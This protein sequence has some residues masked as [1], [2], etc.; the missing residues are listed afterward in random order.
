MRNLFINKSSMFVLN[1]LGQTEVVDSQGFKTGETINTYSEPVFFMAH[2]SGARGS[3]QAEMFGT[4]INYDKTIL[5]SKKSYGVL[6]ITENSVFFIGKEPTYDNGI[7][8]YNYKVS[9]IAET[10]NEVAIAVSKVRAD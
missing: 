1:Y 4:E 10:I 2:I 8:L 3:S 7:P 5:L 6:G 9:K